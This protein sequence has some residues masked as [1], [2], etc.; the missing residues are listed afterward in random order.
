MLTFGNGAAITSAL[1]AGSAQIGISNPIQLANAIAHGIPFRL[2]A[3]GG[4][5]TA[6]APTTLLCVAKGA[7]LAAPRDLDGK[8][9]AISALKS[10]DEGALKEWLGRNG[11]SAATMRIVELPFSEMGAALARGTL[12]AA[13]IAEPAL[14]GALR[15]GQVRVFGKPFDAVAPR[16]L[17]GAWF[18][19]DDFVRANPDVVRTFVATIYRT[20]RWANANQD[21]SAQILNKYTKISLD[22]TKNMT[23]I[24]YSETIT[25]GL[26]QPMLDLAYKYRVLQTPVAAAGMIARSS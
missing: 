2:I 21:A 24:V 7:A 19:T 20:A 9:I 3:G 5:Y 10:T 23:R 18:A 26:M 22:S 1:A 14:E 13:M 8:T 25:A 15:A 6:T 16:F 4:M 12:D 17:I 11:A